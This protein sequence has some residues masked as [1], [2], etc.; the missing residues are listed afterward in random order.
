MQC[1]D[2]ERHLPLSAKQGSLLISSSSVIIQDQMCTIGMVKD[3]RHTLVD[4]SIVVT[5][6]VVVVV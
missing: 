4:I 2:M 6:L 3:I 5:S 1:Q